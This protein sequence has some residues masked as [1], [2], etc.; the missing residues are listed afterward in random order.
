[1]ATTINRL[2]TKMYINLANFSK[3][4]NVPYFQ[5]KKKIMFDLKTIYK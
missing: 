2:K 5:K 1:M 3:I 4:L